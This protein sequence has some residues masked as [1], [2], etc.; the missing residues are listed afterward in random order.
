M[1]NTT[2]HPSGPDGA[3]RLV[4]HRYSADLIMPLA[5]EVEQAKGGDPLAPVTVVGPTIYSNLTLRRSLGRTGFA[6]VKFLVFPR[7]SEYLGAP[8]LAA[9]GIRP[10]TPIVEGA[11]V[12]AVVGRTTGALAALGSHPS[13]VRSLR[14]TFRQIRHATD[15]A[16]DR[17]ASQGGLR[18]EVAVLYRDFRQ[19]TVDY[20]DAED[21]AQSAAREVR[22]GGAAGLTDLGFIVFFLIR[23]VTPGERELV[24]ALAERGNCSVFLGLTAEPEADSPAEKLAEDLSRH[25]GSPDRQGPPDEGKQPS[26]GLT[27]EGKQLL[28]APGPHEEVRWAIRQLA[29]RAEGDAPLHRMAVLYGARTPYETLVREELELAGFPTAGPDG[30]SLA[31]TAVGRVLRGLLDL[32]GS[33][34][35]RHDVMAWLTG[36]PVRVPGIPDGENFSPS[37]WDA[38]SRKAGVISGVSQWQDRLERYAGETERSAG[39]RERKGEISEAQADL[40]LAEARA[41]R[42][43]ARFVNGL[44]SDLGPPGKPAEG[45]L[46]WED[47]ARWTAGLFER[48]LAS[49]GQLPEHEQSASERILDILD[50]IASAGEVE[51]SP[52]MELFRDTLEEA[53]QSP[54]GHTGETGQGVFVGPIGSA[55]GMNFDTVHI[56]GMIEG[57]VPSHSG[58]DPLLPDRERE[59]AGGPAEGLPLQRDRLAEER[60]AF[61]SALASTPEAAVSYPRAD[62]AGQR[63]HYPSRWFTGLASVIEGAPVYTSG[64]SSLS[65]RDWLTVIP[66]MERALDTIAGA[67]PA[68]MHDY[69]LERLRAWKE[70]GIRVSAH[71][72]AASGILRKSL[73]MGRGRYASRSLTEWDGNVSAAAPGTGFVGR[74]EDS[75]LSPT[76]LEQWAACPF[77]YF[78]GHVLRVSALEDREDLFSISAMDRGSL[79]HQVL[80]E[81][82]EAVRREDSMPQPGS[83]WTARHRETLDRIAGDAFRQAESQGKTGR[84]L[85]WQLERQDILDD[86][87]D[88]LEADTA[89]RAQFGMS[90]SYS[91][92]AFGMGGDSWPAPEL[93]LDS[94]GSVRFRGYIDRV[95][96]DAEHRNV[97]VMDYKTGSPSSYRR[98]KDDPIDRGRRLQLAVYSLAARNALGPGTEVQA[99]YWFVSSRGRFEIA[100]AD[101]VDISDEATLNRLRDGVSTIVSGI[102][103]G[104]FPANP[105]PPS[106]GDFENC[107][108]CDFKPMCPARKDA[109]W[110]RKK[111][112]PELTRYLELSGE[113]LS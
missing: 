44:A 37:H 6:N 56:V 35:K 14:S 54:V 4:L 106:W 32:Y 9:R 92:A 69:D 78:A 109:L 45:T 52:A 108:F 72:L 5:R 77:R 71:P 27:P 101:P 11:A 21:L 12:R 34:F 91:E 85:M 51:P 99:A 76:S 36:C 58:D 64:L 79:V 7:L 96:S 62:P 59:A 113:A 95:D 73:E 65:G 33:E 42:S 66:S 83:T 40:M 75:A 28:I 8:A 89:L 63:A 82:I 110:E 112:H 30:T 107:R 48:Y 80:E 47:Y 31:R 102:K 84:R 15:G 98:L 43:L 22:S 20:Y 105:G 61:L 81:F 2:Q 16:L 46:S 93:G 67:V 24:Q 86:L 17:L 94:G 87:H 26:G 104:L 111:G 39:A 23:S 88:F 25:L 55:T 90:P 10:L 3:P 100:P 41:A 70:A 97:L 19:Q 29:R 1:A 68:D 13:T 53:L 103:G 18:R 49:P 60:H 74:L 38:I 57:A 50:G